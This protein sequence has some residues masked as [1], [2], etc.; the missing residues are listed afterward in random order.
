MCNCGKCCAY[1][2]NC[3]DICDFLSFGCCDTDGSILGV[4]RCI[5]WNLIFW[6]MFIPCTLIGSVMSPL[7]MI[8]LRFTPVGDLFPNEE[9]EKGAGKRDL[10]IINDLEI[11]VEQ[12]S[13]II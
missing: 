3:E 1:F 8:I 7:L 13:K 12:P 9:G 5:C 10:E 2:C 4:S 11:I 6:I